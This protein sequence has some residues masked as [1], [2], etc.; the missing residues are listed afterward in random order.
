MS[1]ILELQKFNLFE[2][3]YAAME[4][5]VLFI[6]IDNR[7]IL[8]MTSTE[9]GYLESSAVWSNNPGLIELAQGYFEL[10]WT[11][12]SEEKIVPVI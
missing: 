2:I 9:K 5:L 1:E 3:E 10:T 12:L 11:T 8:L 6:L 7:E 4:P